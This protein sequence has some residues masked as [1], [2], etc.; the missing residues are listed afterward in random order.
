MANFCIKNFFYYLYFA[1]LIISRPL[2]CKSWVFNLNMLP[3]KECNTSLVNFGMNCISISGVVPF[4]CFENF[5][6]E[7]LSVITYLILI[8]G[9]FSSYIQY[10][11][12]ILLNFDIGI[13]F[14]FC[15]KRKP[16]DTSIQYLYQEDTTS[17]CC[18]L[19]KKNI[20]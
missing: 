20:F 11:C 7:A 1:G 6:C 14:L 17:N 19:I 5:T 2:L 13:F 4:F 16:V 8:T 10:L 9:S 15:L 12:L 18:I 3:Y